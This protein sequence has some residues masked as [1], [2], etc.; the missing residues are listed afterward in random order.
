METE[1]RLILFI[2]IYSIYFKIVEETPSK[3]LHVYHN[4]VLKAG[5]CLAQKDIESDRMR[6]F[7]L[8]GRIGEKDDS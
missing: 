1:L 3:I 4:Y 5:D 8:Y 6:T 7:I 2:Q